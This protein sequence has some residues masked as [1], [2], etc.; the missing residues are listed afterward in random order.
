MSTPA[1][2]AR[3]ALGIRL[4]DIRREAG[5]TGRTLATAAGWH[6]TRVSKL[7]HG[8]LSASEHDVR[9]WCQLCKAEGQIPDLVATVQS[10]DTMFME[11]RR[12]LRSGT[13]HRQKESVRFEA[14]TQFFRVFEPLFIPGLLQTAEYASAVLSQ[15]IS[16]HDLPNDLEE[17]VEARMER[18]RIL[19]RGDRRFHMVFCE[20]AL[21]LG[22]VERPVL[23]SQI[24]RLLAASSIPHVHMG[25][26][27]T[28]A[29]HGFL[30][31]HGFW[32]LDLREVRIETISAEIKLTQPREVSVYR[33]AFDRFAES[34]VY[35]R[36]AREL[37]LSAM[38]K[39]DEPD[40]HDAPSPPAS[41]P[42]MPLLGS[43]Q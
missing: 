33:R 41:P 27:P 40:A 20:V 3:E 23:L 19:Y 7:E 1:R 13:R 11:W 10:I 5:L 6:F 16:F 29:P 26:I 17:G 8:V 42:T 31:L 38:R 30:P 18:Q 36:A 32:I 37:L 25:I 2:Q 43:S 28:R 34:A 39:L 14:E 4:R 9:V 35:G 15:F 12:Q 21:T 24:D 22:I